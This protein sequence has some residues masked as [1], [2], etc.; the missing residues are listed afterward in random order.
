MWHVRIIFFHATLPRPDRRKEGGVTVFV[1]RLANELVRR[2]NDVCVATLDPRPQDAQYRHTA[3]AGGRLA[4]SQ[5]GRAALL[6]FLLRSLERHPADVIHTHGDDHFYWPR[7]RPTL[8]TF[9]GSAAGEAASATTLKRRAFQYG[10]AHLERLASRLPDVV[11]SISRDTA[12]RL[13]RNDLVIPCAVD[14]RQFHPGSGDAR[15]PA[16]AILF[17]GTVRGRKRGA[18]LVEHFRRT[19]RLRVPDA[20]LWMVSDAPDPGL[21]GV[22]G[23]RWLGKVEDDRLAELYREA[24]VFCLPSTYEGFGIPYVE[25]LASGTPVIATDNPGAREILGG[26]GAHGG[27]IVGDAALGAALADLLA[28]GGE[29]DRLARRGL[30]R[31]ADFSL[32]RVAAAYEAAYRL[33]MARHP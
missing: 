15:S 25:A 2:G 22:P 28:D 30:T 13:P 4:A 8:R 16:P 24:W 9:Y 3:L 1:H 19:V 18:W 31:A 17:V 7:R 26:E 23:V 20:E 12:G 6:P 5:I 11:V 27:R 14:R 32:D 21:E 10:K 33:A 29:R